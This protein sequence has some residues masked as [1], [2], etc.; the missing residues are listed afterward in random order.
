[1]TALLLP[2]LPKPPPKHTNKRLSTCNGCLFQYMNLIISEDNK[3]IRHAVKLKDRK[4][5]DLYGEYLIEGL[6]GV[7][8]TPS[9][10]ILTIFEKEGGPS[11]IEG[12]TVF[13]SDKIFSKLS[14]TENSQGIV[15][16]AKKREET[17]FV[18]DCVVYLDRIRDP[19]NM[20]TI[21]RT[22]VAA[23]YEIVC[24]D[25][26]DVYNPK[27][28]RSCVSTLSKARLHTGNFIDIV[29]E[30]GYNIIGAVLNGENVFQLKEN[31]KKP[32]I[33]I[34]N[35]AN[36]IREDILRKCGTLC[37]IPMESVESL[38]AA[39]CAGILMYFFKY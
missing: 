29:V 30:K 22:A 32:C 23:G 37:S 16:I 17:D 10:R 39:V 4:Y 3:L 8:D 14:S 12:K 18:S 20:G 36:G 21:I 6:R 7:A 33:V 27:V 9:D 13:V 24:D 28:V 2:S 15:A 19:G 11:V 34:G 5:R 1:M 35:E 31:P 25:C 38:N 26:V